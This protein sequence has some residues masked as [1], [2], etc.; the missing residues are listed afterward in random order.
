MKKIIYRI[1]ATG[2]ISHDSD[3]DEY[4]RPCYK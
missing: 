4:F 3:Y 1:K 2:K